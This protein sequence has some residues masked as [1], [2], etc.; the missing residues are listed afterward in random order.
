MHTHSATAFSIREFE[1][2]MNC[3]DKYASIFLDMIVVGIAP[4]DTGF[5]IRV[6]DRFSVYVSSFFFVEVHLFI[7]KMVHRNFQC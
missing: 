2:R 3:C 7:L 5:S 1:R 4:M 6:A